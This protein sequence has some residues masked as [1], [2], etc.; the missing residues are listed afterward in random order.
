MSELASRTS[1]RRMFL[2]A[3]IA[4][5]LA[6]IVGAL[7][8][9]KPSPPAAPPRTQQ[10]TFGTFSK[11]MGNAPFHIAKAQGW[12]ESDPALAGIKINYVEY[13]DRPTIA[14]AFENGSLD[15]LFSGEVP[16]I[17]IR[18]QGVKTKVVLVSGFAS[19]EILVPTA[20]KISKVEDLRGKRIAVQAGTTSHYALFRILSGANL[21]AADLNIAYMPA[22]EGKAAFE[23]KMLD[24]WAA[25]APWVETQQVAGRGKVLQGGSELIYSVGTMREAF[26][27]ND[28]AVARAIYLI[29]LRA[30][31]WMIEH[32]AEAQKIIADDLGF[33]IEV[34][35]AAWPKFHWDAEITD[36]VARDFQS[37]AQF[38]ADEKLS[39]DGTVVEVK[40]Q[41][42]DTSLSAAPTK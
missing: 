28:P 38:L 7:L 33:D 41:L 1:S 34:V 18:S 40:S 25:W 20:S 5:L 35:R 17:L 10:I 16:S 37:K 6:G 22:A 30:K 42:I 32:P 39:R 4:I 27:Q 13:G 11:A 8:Y 26:I 24:A 3:L 23:S 14:S 29:I 31:N 15:V 19:Q 2:A 21:K 36:A 12:F 9:F